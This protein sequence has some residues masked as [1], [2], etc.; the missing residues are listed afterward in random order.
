MSQGPGDPST[1]SALSLSQPGTEVILNSLVKS[2]G[3]LGCWRVW[4]EPVP[5]V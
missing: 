4:E 1:P 5:S 2:S 3:G